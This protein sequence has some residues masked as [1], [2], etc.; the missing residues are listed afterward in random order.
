MVCFSIKNRRSFYSTPSSLLGHVSFRN[1]QGSWYIQELCNVI[2]SFDPDD[3]S[4][5]DI[6]TATNSA[7][8]RRVSNVDGRR[9]NK[10]QISSF[11]ST[12]TKK[13]YFM[14]RPLQG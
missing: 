10:K 2:E 8:S 12:L 14:P 6:L 3:E 4:I 7:V 5:L 9:N 11:Y 13:L 1:A